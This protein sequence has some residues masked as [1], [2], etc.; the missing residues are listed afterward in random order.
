MNSQ[1]VYITKWP[2]HA[3]FAMATTQAKISHRHN[4]LSFPPGVKDY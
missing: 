4:R 1:D 3:I 2:Y